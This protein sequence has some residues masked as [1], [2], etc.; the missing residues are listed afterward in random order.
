MIALLTLFA[1][2]VGISAAVL[3]VLG[4]GWVVR[5]HRREHERE[6]GGL[7]DPLPPYRPWWC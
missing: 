5:H 7:P 2:W 4:A 6:H 1:W 3:V